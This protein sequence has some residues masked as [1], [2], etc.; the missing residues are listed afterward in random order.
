MRW[1]QCRFTGEMIPVD[2]AARKKDGIFIGA[3]EFNAFKSPIDGAIITTRRQYEDHMERHNVV[4]AAEFTPEFYRKK[5]EERARLYN[6]E[7]TSA[8][9]HAR[10]M[11][12]AGIYEHHERLAHNN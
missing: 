8:E 7:H 4:P 2:D 10:K 11:E 5:A 9:K 1:R 3:A 6:G 12:I